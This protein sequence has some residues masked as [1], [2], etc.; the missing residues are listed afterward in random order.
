MAILAPIQ[1]GVYVEYQQPGHQQYD[2]RS[3]IRPM[4]GPNRPW[5]AVVYL[6]PSKFRLRFHC[7]N[8]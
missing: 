8:F 1:M 4:P 3:R 2:Y 7:G 5:M 6:R